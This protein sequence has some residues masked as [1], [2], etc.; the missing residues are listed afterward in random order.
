MSIIKNKS[1]LLAYRQQADACMQ[2]LCAGDYEDPDALHRD[3]YGFIKAKYLLPEDLDGIYDLTELA[4]MSVART[5]Q[6]TKVD[7][8]KADSA[9]SCEGTTSAMNK[10]VLLLMALQKGMQICFLPERT[11]ELT[12]T[13]LLADEVYRLVHTRK[14]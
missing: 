6:M 11:A 12:D 1:G 7:A 4:Q 13:K 8:F 9:H 2:R 14:E 10:K 5:I 3:L